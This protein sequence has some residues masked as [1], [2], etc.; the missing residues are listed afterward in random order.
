M[1][2]IAEVDEL[3]TVAAALAPPGHAHLQAQAS[4]PA[5]PV[6]VRLARAH[7]FAILC[8]LGL[9]GAWD[10]AVE[11][12]LQWGC[13]RIVGLEVAVCDVVAMQVHDPCQCGHPGLT[14]SGQRCSM[15]HAGA[16]LSRSAW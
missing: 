4:H 7:I 12:A 16:N 14:T 10:G 9:W 11:M 3:D 2:G 6:S 13:A 15:P 5:V 8:S 1:L